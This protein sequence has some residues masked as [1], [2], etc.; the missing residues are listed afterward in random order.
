LGSQFWKANFLELAGNT[1]AEGKDELHSVSLEELE[2]FQVDKEGRLYWKGKPVEISRRLTKWQTVGAFVVG[3][4]V[5]IGGIGSCTQGWVS[6]NDLACRAE[7]SVAI[8]P[9]G[10]HLEGPPENLDA[11]PPPPSGG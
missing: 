1:M 4:F 7:W 10:D 2:S 8:C 3:F 11:R 6:Y 9:L 5:V